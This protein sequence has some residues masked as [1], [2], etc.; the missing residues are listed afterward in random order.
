[1]KKLTLELDQLKVES[2]STGADGNVKGTVRAH[3]NPTDA[4]ASDCCWTSGTDANVSD[5][6]DCPV[7]GGGGGGGA[8]H[9]PSCGATCRI[10]GIVWKCADG[11][12]FTD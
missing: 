8:S 4:L 10:T 3:G 11:C 5:L 12:G 9:A 6:G 2:F 7:G 1:M